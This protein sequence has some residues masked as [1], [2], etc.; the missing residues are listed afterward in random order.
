MRISRRLRSA[1]A[2]ALTTGVLL[3]LPGA[4]FAAADLTITVAKDASTPSV[5]PGSVVK[6][7]V[8]VENSGDAPVG[9][10]GGTVTLDASHDNVD[11]TP[12]TING[13][14]EPI[15]NPFTAVGGDARSIVISPG[16]LNGTSST[17]SFNVTLPNRRVVDGCG[18]FCGGNF[19]VTA[20]SFDPDLGGTNSGTST[21]V[22][23]Y[24]GDGTKTSKL[25]I[26]ASETTSSPAGLANWWAP[27]GSTATTT[28]TIHN[29]GDGAAYD[30]QVFSDAN[31][32][33][34]PVQPAKPK[35]DSPDFAFLTDLNVKTTAG[36]ADCADYAITPTASDCLI[37][38]IAAGGSKTV[39]VTTTGLDFLGMNIQNAADVN[40]QGLERTRQ[41]TAPGWNDGN[42]YTSEVSAAEVKVTDGKAVLPRVVVD[43]PVAANS[44]SDVTYDV[45]ISNG[46][47]DAITNGVLRIAGPVFDDKGNDVGSAYVGD[48]K[49]FGS[50]KSITIPGVTCGDST[51]FTFQNFTTGKFETKVRI[52]VNDCIVTNLPSGARITGKVVANFPTGRKDTT[53]AGDR[54]NGGGAYDGHVSATLYSAHFHKPGSSPTAAQYTRL[55]RA[56]NADLDISVKS[57]AQIGAQRLGLHVV[58]IKNN[59]PNT[60]KNVQ[61]N[62]SL[63]KLV[64][65]FEPTLMPGKCSGVILTGGISCALD[66][67]ESGKSISVTIPV[68]GAKKLGATQVATYSAYSEEF[69]TNPDNNTVAHVQTVVKASLA[70][71][72]GVKLVKAPAFLKMSVL[73]KTG[74]K[75]T[76]TVPGASIVTVDLTVSRLVAQKAGL[77]K[78]TGRAKAPAFIKIGTGRKV[79]KASGKVIVF[80]KLLPT[81]KAK[82]LKLRTLKVQRVTTVVSTATLTKGATYL[83]TS[84]MTLRK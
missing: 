54:Q 6:Y 70:P 78:A 12:V 83:A 72:T 14:T 30:V 38:E 67:I 7:N 18:G 42:D 76:V 8:T 34:S 84:N 5:D 51:N 68:L 75:S 66:D 74:L 41:N 73:A 63:Y 22:E 47:P 77:V 9:N 3:A 59:G 48:E 58:T 61:L 45:E 16:F 46:G 13:G 23:V 19:T 69:D 43:G 53:V 57:A 55:N 26:T 32:D 29:W 60:A 20:S 82:V 28:F 71:L 37:G 36:S 11:G 17:F 81:Y 27:L 25:Y 65:S 21:G 39:T 79:M 62:G 31:A 2:A 56:A 52:G 10:D 33:T 35:A 40:N 49:R 1:F 44:Q 15:D 24:R 4:A 80:T 64:G 50:I